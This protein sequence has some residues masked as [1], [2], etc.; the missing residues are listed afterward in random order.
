MAEGTAC[1]ARDA[2]TWILKL[3]G[4]LRHTLGPALNALLDRVFADPGFERMAI[5][6]SAAESI[7][8]TCL[9]VLARIGNQAHQAS[10]MPPTIICNNNDINELLLALCFDR[11]FNLVNADGVIAKNLQAVPVPDTDE[12]A[13]L[14][15]VLEA[16]RRLCD[17]DQRNS[18]VFSDVVKL[19]EN[20]RKPDGH[21]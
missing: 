12:G 11:L 4:E 7:D 1:Y 3:S 15:V 6:L 9:G 14:A 5:D 13:L 8:S 19:M 18:N 2:G 16:H 17:M 20:E 21:D 10:R